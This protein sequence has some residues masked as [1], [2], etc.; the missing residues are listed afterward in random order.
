MPSTTK[1]KLMA[2]RSW[3]S[4]TRSPETLRCGGRL[5]EISSDAG[6]PRATL[7][8]HPET[9]D[10]S[11]VN[12]FYHR[13]KL[14]Y[15]DAADVKCKL[16]AAATVLGPDRLGYSADDI[17]TH[18]LRSGAAMAMYLNDVP[19]YTIMLV[20]RW[21]SDAFLKYIRRQVQQFSAGVSSRMIQTPHFFTVPDTSNIMHDPRTPNNRHSLAS[22]NGRTPSEAAQMPAFNLF[23]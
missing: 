9:S 11:P 2:E 21:S 7:G 22:H 14:T 6:Q 5:D 23:T 16:R 20:G 1:K 15:V 13:G 17:G 3:S 12:T 4:R 18:S 10:E 8:K 19:V